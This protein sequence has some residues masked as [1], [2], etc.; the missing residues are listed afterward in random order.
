[1]EVRVRK[2]R[3]LFM[4]GGGNMG[5]RVRVFTSLFLFLFL[6]GTLPADA[7][8]RNNRRKKN[9]A[10]AERLRQERALAEQGALGDSESNESNQEIDF[11][12]DEDLATSHSDTTAGKF[13]SGILLPGDDGYKAPPDL[14]SASRRDLQLFGQP[15][16]KGVLLGESSRPS[17]SRNGNGSSSKSDRN[18]ATNGSGNG[19]RNGQSKPQTNGGGNG[20]AAAKGTNGEAR[21]GRSNGQ[22]KGAGDFV[23]EATEEE[24]TGTSLRSR[25]T[26]LLPARSKIPDEEAASAVT[27]EHS[28]GGTGPT[29][30]ATP[31]PRSVPVSHP[32]ANGAVNG[33]GRSQ[34]AGSELVVSE[35]PAAES[36]RRVKNLVPGEA[37]VSKS[38]LPDPRH[39][40]NVVSS[41]LPPAIDGFLV[42]LLYLA[43]I[44]APTY[45]SDASKL[46]LAS[47]VSHFKSGVS[48]LLKIYGDREAYPNYW[49]PIQSLNEYLGATEPTR[50]HSGSV[51]G[52]IRRLWYYVNQMEEGGED[53]L[54]RAYKP[55]MP[56]SG[57]GDFATEGLN[58]QAQGYRYEV[59]D[60]M[61]KVITSAAVSMPTG[62]SM[63]VMD[64]V[65]RAFGRFLAKA[66]GTWGNMLRKAA[67]SIETT[68]IEL[69]KMSQTKGL[70]EQATLPDHLRYV[71]TKAD[72]LNRLTGVEDA[73]IEFLR[74]VQTQDFA[75]TAA[76]IATFE[77]SLGEIVGSLRSLGTSIL[78][79]N[80]V[81]FVTP[82]RAEERH[83]FELIR[84]LFD[85]YPKL[86]PAPIF[87]NII[88]DLFRAPNLNS[89]LDVLVIML[90][91]F[92]PILKN[93][94]QTSSRFA[95]MDA[96]A[97]TFESLQTAANKTVP[98][99]V[100]EMIIRA[101]P[102]QYELTDISHEPL[103]TGKFFQ[104]HLAK[105]NGKAVVVRVM[106]PDA[107]VILE[108]ELQILLHLA[109]P[110][111]KI[112]LPSDITDPEL[113]KSIM[114]KIVRSKHANHME[115]LNIAATVIHQN[116][117]RKRFAGISE[118]IQTAR[119]GNVKLNL[120]VPFAYP[121][122]PDS[123]VMVCDAVEGIMPLN[124][125]ASE[126]PEVA[127]ATADF[128][129]KEFYDKLVF[130][131]L[132]RKEPK[133]PELERAEIIRFL[134]EMNPAAGAAESVLAAIPSI[135]NAAD[136]DS[137][138]AHR[139][140]HGGNILF[141]PV[142]SNTN[143]EFI[144][145][146]IDWG[147]TSWVK[148][149]EIDRIAITAYGAEFNNAAIITEN[150]FK[151]ASKATISKKELYA[152]V[153]TKSMELEA[154]RTWWSPEEWVIHFWSH[155]QLEF[156]AYVVGLADAK[157]AL[158]DLRK[159]LT[160]EEEAAAD[161]FVSEL[162]KGSRRK[163][164][165]RHAWRNHPWDAL[166]SG[167]VVTRYS[168]YKFLEC[169]RHI[170]GSAKPVDPLNR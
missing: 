100:V 64:S 82:S 47:K 140:L 91:H 163:A 32:S 76:L 18:V 71:A 55:E 49:E 11:G 28:D 53:A 34:H 153:K 117:A 65:L 67:D 6:V 110:L 42:L 101:D 146:P 80:S 152:L 33:N 2:E 37:V 95:A 156:P 17:S 40:K 25:L 68:D 124:K 41:G 86:L 45:D 62:R 168:K 23:A 38:P 130:E 69:Q 9:A 29:A 162:F 129:T 102:N 169:A 120:D 52:D 54:P 97:R 14:R 12:D 7:S 105:M 116:A 58:Y 125:V 13:G 155:G 114:R 24:S 22:V 39:Q 123:R 109:G 93:F 157:G 70:Q 127:Q 143:T 44:D 122:L 72:A 77:E 159:Q 31:V 135:A 128:L 73:F 103:A 106:L 56:N 27:S 118:D 134:R 83:I 136:P 15:V 78:E 154:S 66:P 84:V 1:M 48:L 161:K 96:L 158:Y 139:D 108:W 150:L 30:A 85:D 10:N 167:Q 21:S 166:L 75:S 104:A 92:G 107:E 148:P 87:K 79:S 131:A 61:R 74:E 36:P 20:T 4:R 88:L 5:A 151:L 113:A 94:L 43:D 81:R 138:V 112:Y 3:V 164:V 19:N 16:P 90:R 115:E 145:N 35:V 111:S 59:S 149:S 126:Y 121:A 137:G 119:G 60:R 98:Y 160:D 132:E 170:A 89:D 26:S 63:T 147:L 141:V 8:S 50:G 133:A 144:I 165:M 46:S 142:L 99:E 51:S 57:K